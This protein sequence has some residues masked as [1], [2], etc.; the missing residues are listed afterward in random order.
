MCRYVVGA[1]IPPPK[2]QQEGQP[3]AAEVDAFH[4]SYYEALQ[5]LWK[6]HAADFPGYQDVQLVIA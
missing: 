5:Q 3:S 1:P 6:V 2:L 4:A